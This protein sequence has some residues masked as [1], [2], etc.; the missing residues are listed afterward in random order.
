MGKLLT[1]L[2]ADENIQKTLPADLFQAEKVIVG[3]QEIYSK[4]PDSPKKNQL[5]IAISESVRIMMARLNPYLVKEEVEG[6]TEEENKKLPD[7]EKPTPR[8]RREQP[9]PPMPPE[10]PETPKDKPEPEG[11]EPKQQPPAPP[12]PPTPS[13]HKRDEVMSCG[14]IKAA[15]NGLTL[16]AKMGDTEAKEIVKTLKNKYKTQNC[17]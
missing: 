8:V 5:A 3:L 4:A 14:E 9:K 17:K 13:P 10:I 6:K 15:I 7:E 16:L 12:Q 11:E 1:I 2:G